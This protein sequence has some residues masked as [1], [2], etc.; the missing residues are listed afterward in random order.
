MRKEKQSGPNDGLGPQGQMAGGPKVL[1]LMRDCAL[2]V[3]GAFSIIFGLLPW[4][5][6]HLLGVFL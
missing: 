4:Q 1:E 6:T 2:Y 3:F 5:S